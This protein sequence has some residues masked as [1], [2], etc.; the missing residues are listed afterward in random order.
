MPQIQQNWPLGKD[1]KSKE[2]GEAY[3]AKA[4]EEESALMLATVELTPMTSISLHHHSD[5]ARTAWTKS[6]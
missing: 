5:I 2:K 4:N 6:R 1:C 3:M